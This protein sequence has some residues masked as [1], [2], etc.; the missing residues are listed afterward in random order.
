M[1]LN[2]IAVVEK[3]PAAR[4][5][6]HPLP[7]PDLR[8]PDTVAEVLALQAVSPL[9]SI[10]PGALLPLPAGWKYAP[11]GL[12]MLKGL[13]ARPAT[14][15]GYQGRP[16]GTSNCLWTLQNLRWDGD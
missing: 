5:P 11:G 9:A 6:A 7:A 2:D 15:W 3:P 8:I 14:M 1:G 16:G 10:T 12:I 13:R 4:P